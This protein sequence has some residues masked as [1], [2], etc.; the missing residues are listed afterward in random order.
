MRRAG[1]RIPILL[2][3][4]G[5]GEIHGPQAAQRGAFNYLVWRTLNPWELWAALHAAVQGHRRALAIRQSEVKFR[6]IIESLEDAYCELDR[7][8]RYTYVNDA[9]CAQLRRTREEILG[10]PWLHAFTPESAT[11]FS[12]SL[13]EIRGGGAEQYMIPGVVLRPDGSS[14]FVELSVMALR[15]KAGRLIGFTSI[16]RDVTEK[17]NAEQV[18]KVMEQMF[19][20]PLTDRGLESFLADW[21]K[22]Q[23]SL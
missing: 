18:L 17:K 7:D 9:Q 15:D 8:G 12:Q 21:K 10:R 23:E 1:P 16:A 14:L 13:E 5:D 3:G 20:H 11:R 19:K 22:F 2:L 6:T 4:D